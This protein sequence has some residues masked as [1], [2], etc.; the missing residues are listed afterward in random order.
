MS[1]WA[2]SFILAA[3]VSLKSIAILRDEARYVEAKSGNTVA[4]PHFLASN[5]ES[6]N[7][8]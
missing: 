4:I 2:L 3:T 6:L 5:S 7:R 1:S 8:Q